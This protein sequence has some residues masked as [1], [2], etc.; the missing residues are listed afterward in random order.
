MD[1]FG[2]RERTN[3]IR[4]IEGLRV[5]TPRNLSEASLDIRR[6]ARAALRKLKTIEDVDEL[7]KHRRPWFSREGQ[8]YPSNFLN[9]RCITS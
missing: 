4:R 8:F 5:E 9:L 1:G 2:F 3:F 7:P 6:A